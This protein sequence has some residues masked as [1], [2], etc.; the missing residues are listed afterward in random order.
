MP[1]TYR[2]ATDNPSLIV[3]QNGRPAGLTELLRRANTQPGLVV[4]AET[5]PIISKYHGHHGFDVN[6]FINDY[7][8]WNKTA[9]AA[10]K[11]AKG[12]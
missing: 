12:E 2:I 5:A 6:R 3:R 8:V 1:D 10:L 7:A 9:N 11:A 4:V